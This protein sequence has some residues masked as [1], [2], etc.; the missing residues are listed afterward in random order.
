ME[1]KD[2][3][4]ENLQNPTFP[5][6]TSQIGLETVLFDFN[7]PQGLTAHDLFSM[8]ATAFQSTSTVIEFLKEQAVK[9]GCDPKQFDYSLTVAIQQMRN[10]HLR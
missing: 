6:V 9:A 1:A 2:K 8:A 10:E 5:S 3:I 7:I 4:V